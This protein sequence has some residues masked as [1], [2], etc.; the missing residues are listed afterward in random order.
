MLPTKQAGSWT[1]EC[2]VVAADR[3]VLGKDLVTIA[4]EPMSLRRAR[5]IVTWDGPLAKTFTYERYRDGARTQYDG[6]DVWGNAT[7]Y[8]RA[9]FTS[10]HSDRGTWKIKGREF[11]LNEDLELA[12]AWEHFEGDTLTH[13]VHGVLTWQPS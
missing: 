2:E 9:L 13:V 5:Q 4:H 1:G 3:T 7:S 8:G 11:L 12:V 10:M 6:P